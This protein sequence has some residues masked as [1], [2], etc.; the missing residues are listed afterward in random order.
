MLH[1]EYLQ[2][3]PLMALADFKY[4]VFIKPDPDPTEDPLYQRMEEELQIGVFPQIHAIKYTHKIF[5]SI[6]DNSGC[7][8]PCKYM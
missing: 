2:K 6:I 8:T 3:C 5:Y 7:K 4:D 1:L